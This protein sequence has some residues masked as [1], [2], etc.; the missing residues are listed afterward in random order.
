MRKKKRC[1]LIPS[2]FVI[3]L[4]SPYTAH[5]SNHCQKQD[6]QP[7]ACNQERS[8]SRATYRCYWKVGDEMYIE[9][10]LLDDH[11][12]VCPQSSSSQPASQQTAVI[13][14][15]TSTKTNT[16]T[17]FV[18]DRTR[19]PITLLRRRS[20]AEAFTLKSTRVF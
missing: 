20:C 2:V 11:W 14:P 16:V 3:M 6:C 15:E 12:H 13:M 7:P 18:Y 9:A 19:P 8:K 17:C 4:H 10:D 5:S 1:A